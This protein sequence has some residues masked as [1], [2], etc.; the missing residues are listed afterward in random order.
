[1][2]LLNLPFYLRLSEQKWQPFIKGSAS[3][4]RRVFSH[5]GRRLTRWDQ[6]NPYPIVNTEVLVS[7]V[8]RC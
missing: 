8:S 7:W 2:G 3:S 1:M 5:G 6:T 4:L